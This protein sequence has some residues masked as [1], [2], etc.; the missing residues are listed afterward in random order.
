MSRK[1]AA[2]DPIAARQRKKAA[3]R[4]VGVNARCACGEDR[5]EALIPGS[6]PMTCAACRRNRK[7]QTP[8]D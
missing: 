2:R 3:E 7:G 8:N 1:M 5:P 6:K 4:R